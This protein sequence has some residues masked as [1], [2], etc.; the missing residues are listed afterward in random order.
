MFYGADGVQREYLRYFPFV[1]CGS[2]YRP[3]K[4]YKTDESQGWLHESKPLLPDR[5]PPSESCRQHGLSAESS[6][7]MDKQDQPNTPTLDARRSVVK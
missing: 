1:V 6:K 3:D 5:C 4:Q 2:D 7:N